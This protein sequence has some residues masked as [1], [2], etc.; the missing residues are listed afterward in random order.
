MA[1]GGTDA[2]ELQTGRWGR[3]EGGEREGRGE[4]I[5]KVGMGEV[6]CVEVGLEPFCMGPDAVRVVADALARDAGRWGG[7]GAHRALDVVI[8]G[9]GDCESVRCICNH[10]L[11]RKV[12]GMVCA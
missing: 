11:R 8:D 1:H 4:D 10:V 9:G 2:G 12:K 5:E 7:L 6:G 3:E